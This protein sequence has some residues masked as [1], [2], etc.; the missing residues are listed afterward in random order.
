MRLNISAMKFINYFLPAVILS[1]GFGVCYAQNAYDRGTPAAAKAGLLNTSSYAPDKVETVNLA[2]GN[3]NVQIPLVTVGGRGA[4]A[5]PIALSYQG[6]VWASQH[7]R[8]VFEVPFNQQVIIDHFRPIQG[9]GV[10]TTPNVIMLGSGW[11]ISKGPAIKWR[12]LESDRTGCSGFVLTK[13]WLLMPDGSEI[14]LRDVD[15]QGAPDKVN[16]ECGFVDRNRGKVWRSVDG[17]AITYITDTANGVVNGEL[18]GWVLLADGTKFKM[19]NGYCTEIIDRNGNRINIAYNTSS[20]GAVTYTDQ[21]GRQYILQGGT[22]G[23]SVTI[24]GYQGVADRVISVTTGRIGEV[25]GGVPVNLRSDYHNVQR[26][27]YSSDYNQFL[28]GTSIGT[29]EHTQPQP[30]TDLFTHGEAPILIDDLL[31]PTQLNFPDGRGFRFRYNKYAELAEVIY[32]DGGVSQIDY[33]F[34]YPQEWC[35]NVPSPFG[36]QIPGPVT[37]RRVLTNGA[38]IDV[39]WKYTR[40]IQFPQVTVEA[41]QGTVAGPLLLWEK[42]YFKAINAEYRRCTGFGSQGT[43]NLKWENGKVEKIER[44]VGDTAIQTELKTWVQRTPVVWENDPG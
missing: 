25:V 11:F 28:D 29:T 42:H 22:D 36:A 6:K 35:E 31:A 34:E 3:F 10:G 13:I 44:K 23:A 7:D 17:S 32:P 30:H 14:E 37:E 2:N 4:A 15:T 12:K 38:N 39:V 27:I 16:N 21:L 33:G 19:G 26:P 41:H 20:A 1:T 43:G 40:D 9:Q 5:F 18:A 24:K 8:E